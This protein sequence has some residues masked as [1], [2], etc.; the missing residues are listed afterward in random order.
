MDPFS[1]LGV[2]ASIIACIQLTGA[3]LKRV[4]P[5]RHS[6]K[7]L[8]RTLTVICGFRGAYEGLKSHLEYNEEDEVRLSALQHLEAPLRDCKQALEGLEERLKTVSFVGQHIVGSFWDRRLKGWLQ[9]LEGAKELFELA[10]HADQ[11]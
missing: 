9:M 1:V 7:D 10:L 6:K 11:Q 3:L 4:G 8:N 5:S 2:T